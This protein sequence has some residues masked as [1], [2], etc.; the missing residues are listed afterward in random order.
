[1]SK[2]GVSSG[3]YFPVL[4]LNTEIY[5][6][7]TW[8]VFFLITAKKKKIAISHSQQDIADA[9]FG[10]TLALKYVTETI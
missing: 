7:S 10:I 5:S 8:M 6:V 4:G 3:S 9:N 2:Y 1:M